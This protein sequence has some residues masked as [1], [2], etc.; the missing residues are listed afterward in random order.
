MDDLQGRQ[1]PKNR[2]RPNSGNPS[3]PCQSSLHCAMPPKS[4]PFYCGSIH[5]DRTI[6]A[7]QPHDLPG[8]RRGQVLIL[9]QLLQAV[10][11][12]QLGFLPFQVVAF[13]GEAALFGAQCFQLVAGERAHELR[14]QHAGEQRHHHACAADRG[15]A[16]VSRFRIG[17]ANQTA[18]V[19]LLAIEED[20]LLRERAQPILVQGARR[21]SPRRPVSA[22]LYRAAGR[23][24]ALGSSFLLRKAGMVAMFFRIPLISSPARGAWRSVKLG[25]GPFPRRSA[26]EGASS[27]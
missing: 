10:H 22:R 21:V 27:E 4:I 2:R 20:I 5:R 15:P 17:L 19:D 12:E 1:V 26:V 6:L 8:R 13:I 23:P 24:V 14:N 9:R 16:R 25:F 3:Q 7:V 18:I 11:I